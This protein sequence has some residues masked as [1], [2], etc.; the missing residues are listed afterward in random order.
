MDWVGQRA[1]ADDTRAATGAAFKLQRAI[2]PERDH[3]RGGRS[4]KDVVNVLFYGDFLCPYCR[5]LRPI[6]VRLRQALGERM[7]YVFRHFP[8]EAA[9]PGATFMAR[10]A[11]AAGKQGRLWEI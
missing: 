2:D 8:N 7:A 11:E 9:H 4:G 1:M 10:A 3:L 5:R 6:M